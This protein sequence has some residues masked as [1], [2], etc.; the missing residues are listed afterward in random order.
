MTSIKN[1]S[2]LIIV[3]TLVN[4]FEFYNIELTLN[5]A[6]LMLIC[7][8]LSTTIYNYIIFNDLYFEIKNNLNL[9]LYP[10]YYPS[11]RTYFQYII[12]TNTFV[13]IVSSMFYSYIYW[14]DANTVYDNIN[15]D[16]I[17][18]TFAI[19]CLSIIVISFFILGIYYICT[20]LFTLLSYYI[21]HMLF[22]Y[23]HDLPILSNITLLP[24]YDHGCWVCNK[25]I[26]KTEYTTQLHCPCNALYHSKCIERYLILHKNVCPNG[27]KILKFKNEV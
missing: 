16:N 14:T 19:V 3:L 20:E 2:V 24:K 10:N 13:F 9:Y 26:M 23:S 12:A 25:K 18:K 5:I 8:S 11:N 6:N 17:I 4:I 27:H 1:N 21:N 22:N 15:N 7:I